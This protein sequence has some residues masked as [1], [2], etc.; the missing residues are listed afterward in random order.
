MSAATK[1]QKEAEVTHKQ[2]AE[3]FE[4][5]KSVAQAAVEQANRMR[6]SAE[7]DR[8]TA[9]KAHVQCLDNLQLAALAHEQTNRTHAAESANIAAGLTD[10]EALRSE[11]RV[12][13]QRNPR[14]PL[15]HVQ[16][17]RWLGGHPSLQAV[18][19]SPRAAVTS[20]AY[21]TVVWSARGRAMRPVLRPAVAGSEAP[22]ACCW[23]LWGGGG[24]PGY[25][26]FLLLA[27]TVCAD[28]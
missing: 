1:A 10:P 21:G 7:A 13:T 5:E 12:P 8:D 25:G 26:Y 11:L 6:D 27:N 24:V 23:C 20:S 22:D 4:K 17:V 28:Q 3:Q 2:A 16:D 15:L 9:R 18:H 19:G 14:C